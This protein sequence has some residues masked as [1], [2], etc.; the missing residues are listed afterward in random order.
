MMENECLLFAGV[1]SFKFE[2]SFYIQFGLINIL[3]KILEKNII[4]W[5][6]YLN[7]HAYVIHVYNIMRLE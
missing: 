3:V 6:F 7:I 2:V 4:L 5:I 1:F